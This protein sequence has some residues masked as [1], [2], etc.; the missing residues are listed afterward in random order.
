MTPCFSGGI[1]SDI[2]RAMRAAR[3]GQAAK[4]FTEQFFVY[5]NVLGKDEIN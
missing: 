4:V 3:S 5:K 1:D 2:W